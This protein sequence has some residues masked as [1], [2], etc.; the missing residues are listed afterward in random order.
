MQEKVNRIT[1]LI[2]KFL[3]ERLNAEEE[4][5]L[6][7]WLAEAEH[8]DSFFQQITNREV[9]REKLKYYASTDSEAIW[10]K[11]LQKID[12]GAKLVD[13]YPTR[14]TAKLLPYG[15]IADAASI[16]ILISASTWF[17]LSQ[18]TSK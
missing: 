18:S 1:S 3:E 13:L 6:K 2:E 9:L 7:E 12:G 15:K 10:N 11:T 14:K 17:Y 5:E 16:L 4:R 8:N